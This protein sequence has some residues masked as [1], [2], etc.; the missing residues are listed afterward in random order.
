M[1]DKLKDIKYC[2]VRE[3]VIKEAKPS[4]NEWNVAILDEFITDRYNVHI[5]KDI[6][7]APKPWTTNPVFLDVKFTN[8][9]RE[10]DRNTKWLIDKVCLHPRMSLDMKVLNCILFR[11]YNKWETCSAIGMPSTTNWYKHLPDGVES[12]TINLL[13]DL[14]RKN[15]DYTFFTSAFNTGGLKSAINRFLKRE[16]SLEEDIPINHRPIKM[17]T[18][19]YNNGLQNDI[20]HAKSPDDVCQLLMTYQGIGEFLS[21]Q[22]FVDFTYIP[23]Y[24]F[25]ENHFTIAGPGCKL[26][27]DHIFDDK[28]GM[29]YEECLFWM[30][31]NWSS[32]SSVDPKELM[33]D[34]PMEDRVM[35]VMSLENL[36]CELGKYIK[37]KN[38]LSD[39]KKPRARV[40]YDGGNDKS[41]PSL[42]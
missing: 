40:S 11:M 14:E 6:E 3:D 5:K 34:L 16:Y 29:S 38:Q 7:C 36:H 18:H 21:Y 39:G 12:K 1:K 2:G 37:C 22:M 41:A 42:F 24:R 33:T 27:L 25:S 32:F 26:G 13:D 28:D 15:P 4:L 30:R 8:V 10:H 20:I 19:M 35:N 17:L 31:D 9:R 23:E